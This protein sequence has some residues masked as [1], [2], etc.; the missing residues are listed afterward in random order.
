[1]G[2]V[3]WLNRWADHHGWVPFIRGT[4]GLT[5]RERRGYVREFNRGLGKPF[6]RSS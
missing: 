5:G 2:S 6:R 4:D 3:T 1:V